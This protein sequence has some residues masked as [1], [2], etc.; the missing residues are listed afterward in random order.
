MQS[1]AFVVSKIEAGR[2]TLFTQDFDVLEFPA[3]LLP[4]GA[5]GSIVSIDVRAAADAQA[6]RHKQIGQVVERLMQSYQVDEAEVG[7][8]R[9]EIGREGFVQWGRRGRTAAVISWK[10]SWNELSQVGRVLLYD[11]ECVLVPKGDGPIMADKK[12]THRGLLRKQFYQKQEVYAPSSILSNGVMQH[13]ARLAEK[14]SVQLEHPSVEW[15]FGVYLVFRTSCGLFRT[16]IIWNSDDLT[17]DGEKNN[18][19]DTYLVV[20]DDFDH[21]AVPSV[22]FISL[23]EAS[24]GAD[25][26]PITAVLVDSE[27]DRASAFASAHHLPTVTASWLQEQET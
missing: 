17:A 1:E 25:L 12:A 19:Q 7:A 16:A 2:A 23:S 9:E 6:A 8:W 4:V 3:E 18:P 21:P 27:S 20:P 11:I 14:R 5:V 13:N 26:L 15:M 22:H 24:A 10:R